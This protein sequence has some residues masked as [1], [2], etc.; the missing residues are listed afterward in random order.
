MAAPVTAA[1]VAPPTR[2]AQASSS[3][4]AGEPPLRQGAVLTKASGGPSQDL[5]RAI[6]AAD[7][8][9][10]ETVLSRTD[11]PP[12]NDRLEGPLPSPLSSGEE[13]PK[14]SFTQQRHVCTPLA[15]ACTLHAYEVLASSPREEYLRVVKL[16]LA[17]GAQAGDRLGEKGMTALHYAAYHADVRLAEVLLDHGADVVACCKMK[18]TEDPDA[19][20]IDG[21]TPLHALAQGFTLTE[22]VGARDERDP[23]AVAETAELLLRRGA[24]VDSLQSDGSTPLYECSYNNN[25]AAARVLLRHG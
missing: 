16:L 5:A 18:R 23:A 9:L 25:C 21:H 24:C 6:F 4:G 1:G 19:K 14:A 2:E 12:I 13:V 20:M 15:Y 8:Q 7:L 3:S 11:A 17:R 10:V 22:T